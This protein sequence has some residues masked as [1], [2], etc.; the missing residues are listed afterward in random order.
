MVNRKRTRAQSQSD[1]A[2]LS[3]NNVRRTAVSLAVAAA[4][5]G[6]MLLP[7]SALAQEDEE[8]DLDSQVI[9][10]VITTGYRSS[11]RNAMMM[12]QNS[13]SIV[14]AVTAEDIGKLPDASIAE[15]L[16]RLPGLT[17]QRLNGRGQQLSIRG[18]GP[19][20]TT[21]LLNGREQVTTGDNRGVEFDQYPSELLSSVVIYKTP[22]ASL[23]G[24]GL[25]GT[26]DMRTIRPLQHGKRVLAGNV[27]YEWTELDALN[28]GSADDGV[29]YT[30][31]YV[32]QFA[33]DTVGIALGLASMSN[34]GQE[35]RFNAWG[36][37]DVS[38]AQV[39]SGT[40]PYVRSSELERDGIIGALEFLPNENLSV[41][42]DAYYSEFDELQE[43]RGIEFPLQGC[44]SGG[45]QPGYTVVNGVAT[46]GQFNQ[47]KGVVRNDITRR[48]SELF[49][50][51][52]NFDFNITE[53][54]RGVVDISTSAVDRKDTILETYSGTGP[55]GCAQPAC[56]LDEL[57]FTQNGD[58]GW[59]FNPSVDYTDPS[60]VT[61]VGPQGWG[62]DVIPGGQAGYLNQPNIEDELN[63]IAIALDRELDGA[64][65][66]IEFGINIATREKDKVADEW[67]LGLTNDASC[68][69]DD[70]AGNCLS[71][72]INS[73]GTTDLSFLGIPGM[74]SYD[75]LAALSDGTYYRSRNP[76]AD[77]VIKSWNVEEDVNLAFVQF[78]VDTQ[79]GD[80]PVTGN[81]GV[82]VLNVDQ[83]SSAFA[84]DGG[85]ASLQTVLY[86]GGTDWT[87]V[88]PSLN[89]TFDVGND[90]YVRFALAR[91][92]ARARMDQIRASFDWSWTEANRT[93]T[94]TDSITDPSPWGG[95]G[96]NPEV[97]P[98]VA[99]AVDLSWEKYFQ[100]GAGYVSVALFYKDIEQ[101]LLDLPVQVDF[102]GFPVPPDPLNLTGDP[103]NDRA[104]GTNLG[105]ITAPVNGDGGDIT[106]IEFSFS[107][108]GDMF[109][110]NPIIANFGIVG[111]YSV[112]DS[113]IK[114]DGSGDE[115]KI[116]GLSEDVANITMYWENDVFSARVS[117]RYR[118]DFSGEVTGFGAGLASTDV[119]AESILDAQISYNFTGNLE[120]LSLTLAGYN[121]TDEPLRTFHG[122]GLVKDYQRYG[123]SYMLG[124]SYRYE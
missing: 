104:P 83:S 77:V 98:W 53:T 15:S 123:A 106:G 47:V 70:G 31:S 18:L 35:E 4:L 103:A 13:E 55:S 114:P 78:G 58:T 94:G 84:A 99:N 41:A 109:S 11:L 54:W 89:L 46:E 50:A 85:G 28:A 76:N 37:N 2:L 73:I 36:Y 75:P 59:V 34:P 93:N 3:L 121:L 69:Q 87:E 49:S 40:K 12:K 56:D 95:S 90:N 102:T 25:A 115:I 113:S 112:T 61:L 111:N 42:F 17:V 96:G 16:A 117:N 110:D 122:N 52:L 57:T 64:I 44:C 79:W 48:E 10:E 45:I 38:G 124:V 26:A 80:F 101:Y 63:Q 21:A 29:R 8:D 60:Q 32:D 120:G 6:A 51:G 82:Q 14:E 23:I 22:D 100:D 118:S 72:P 19:D 116:P 107:L 66:S 62:G 119:D 39:I 88:L 27:R 67:F 33:D 7:A 86:E 105:L 1:D 43:L 30:L 5:P 108:A 20:F 68:L 65:S 71:R 81:F 24:A 92:V 9:E 91:T 74:L 97:E